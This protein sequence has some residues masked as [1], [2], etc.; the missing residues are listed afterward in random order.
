MFCA[1]TFEDG[2]LAVVEGNSVQ[3][4][5]S[6]SGL[7][8]GETL[9]IGIVASFFNFG[10]NVQRVLWC[11]LVLSSTKQI[12]VQIVG[13]SVWLLGWHA[14]QPKVVVHNVL[15]VVGVAS[16]EPCKDSMGHVSIVLN[17]P[18]QD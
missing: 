13:T 15:C 2:D 1:V 4:C 6:V 10:K 5:I 16:A 14:H 8:P 18:I 9:D 3:V 7:L 17:V 11:E 12:P